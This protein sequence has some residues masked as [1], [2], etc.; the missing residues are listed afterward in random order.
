MNAKEGMRR[1]GILLG[2]LGAVT[3]GFLAYLSAQPIWNSHRKFEAIMRTPTGQSLTK[4]TKAW[5]VP[6]DPGALNAKGVAKPQGWFPLIELK[7][8]SQNGE[9]AWA[10][11]KIR[12]LQEIQAGATSSERPQQ[13]NAVK[14][15]QYT[16]ADLAA[17]TLDTPATAT[18][19]RA[20]V[21]DQIKD[22]PAACLVFDLSTAGDFKTLY[23]D[24]GGAISSVELTT[25]ESLHREPYSSFLTHLL[26]LLLYPV[27]GF[28]A[29]WVAIRV[30]VWVGAGFFKP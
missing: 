18:L 29:P 4:A 25:G 30:V 14:Q 9:S 16:D 7:Q 20:D 2:T 19:R 28:L 11:A 12:D 15:G 10:L 22:H 17:T 26:P 5:P 8:S 6:C 13:A 27:L 1:L 23:V 24:K 21:F 3:G